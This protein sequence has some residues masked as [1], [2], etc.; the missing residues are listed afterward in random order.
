MKLTI[1]WKELTNSQNKNEI[2]TEIIRYLGTNSKK[3][4]H[5]KNCDIDKDVQRKTCILKYMEYNLIII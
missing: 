2:K 3:T 5:T 1:K 4:L